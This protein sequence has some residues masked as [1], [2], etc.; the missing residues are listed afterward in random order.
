METNAMSAILRRELINKTA[1]I[2]GSAAGT[3][4]ANATFARAQAPGG[5]NMT[6]ARLSSF[7]DALHAD[8]PAADRADKMGLYGWLIGRWTFDAIYHLT[9]GT[10][11]R[12]RGEIH[13]GWVLE[14][15]ALQDVWIVPARDEPRADPPGPGDFFGTTLRVYDPKLDAW[16]ILWTDPLNQVYRQ[17][18]G[19]ARGDDIVQDGT[20]EAGTPVRWSFTE[21]TPNSFRWLG[22]R[23]PD[24]G[25]TFRLL[26]EFLARRNLG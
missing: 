23:S 22:E 16:H 8:H 2:A 14:G 7:L 17:Q 26:V 19:R 3:L 15:R 5:S 6:D 20:D 12:G 25:T 21:I 13:A 1:L 24:G 10:T 18:I 11:R 4:L 9:D